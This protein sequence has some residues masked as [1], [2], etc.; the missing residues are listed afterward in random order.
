[1]LARHLEL[2]F[3]E[4]VETIA[5]NQRSAWHAIMQLTQ[6]QRSTA[7]SV[8]ALAEALADA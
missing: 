6:E 2:P 5:Q 7:K 4:V 3:D 8:D 1:M